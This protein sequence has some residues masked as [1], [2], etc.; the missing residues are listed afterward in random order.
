MITLEKLCESVYEDLNGRVIAVQSDLD[1]YRVI[2]ECDDW[3]D[4]EQRRRFEFAFSVVLESTVTPSY[5]DCLEVL[6]DHPI[7]WRHNN[8]HFEAYFSSSP[9]NPLELIGR[10][11][12]A[13][14]RQFGG[15]RQLDEYLH[16]N[17]VILAGGH[18]LLAKGPKQV[19]DE[20]LAAIG[21]R[22]RYSI[23]RGHTP[24]GGCRIMLFDNYYVVFRDVEVV[25]REIT[26]QHPE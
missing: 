15:W 17:S 6:D 9:S 18:G 19:V 16:A 3:N 21:D 11:Y 10:L 12:E 24:Q 1:T 20:Y 8:E 4:Y 14:E 26:S 13:H 25:E 5:C 22:L 23:V 7:L 2:F